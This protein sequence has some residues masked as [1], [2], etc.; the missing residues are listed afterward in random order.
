MKIDPKSLTKRQRHLFMGN[1][2]VPRPIALV[3]TI[4]K[5]GVLNLAPFSMFGMLSRDPVPTIFITPG[6]RPDGSK[7]DTLVNIEQVREFVINMVTE[8]IAEKMNMASGS[9]P[10]EVDEFEV[11]G[12]TPLPCDLVKAPRVAESPF[13][14][15][16]RLT[17]IMEWGKPDI[18]A[19]TILGEVLRVHV[20][21]ALYSDGIIDATSSHLI[22]RM[23]WNL[24]TRTRDLFEMRD[25]SSA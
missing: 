23:G 22:G 21:D 18:T 5:N 13:N 17:Q 7:K 19:E 6:R 4:S 15:E 9:Y 24:Y 3:S 11:T 25:P 2:V 16:C 20:I 8:D 14:L 12:L 10:P 1:L